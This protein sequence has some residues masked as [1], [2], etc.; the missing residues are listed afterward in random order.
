ME[1]AHH[2]K[3][4]T[5]DTRQLR[6]DQNIIGLESTQQSTELSIVQML[7]GA[8]G[9]LNPVVDMEPFLITE[10]QDLEALVFGGLSVVDR[11]DTRWHTKRSVLQLRREL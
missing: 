6:D 7:G 5:P 9:L 10:L 1:D 2:L 4:G 11:Y 3:E 8:D